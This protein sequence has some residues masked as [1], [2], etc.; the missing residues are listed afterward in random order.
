MVRKCQLE[1]DEGYPLLEYSAQ[2]AHVPQRPG[3]FLVLVRQRVR[4]EVGVAIT[5][6]LAMLTALD[7]RNPYASSGTTRCHLQ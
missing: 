3:S 7:C 2:L 5:H 6:Q 4:D 1:S